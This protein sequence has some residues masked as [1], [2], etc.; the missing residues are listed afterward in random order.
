MRPDA[1]SPDAPVAGFNSRMV[2]YVDAKRLQ[3]ADWGRVVGKYAAEAKTHSK[4]LPFLDTYRTMCFAPPP[5][6][7]RVLEK[8]RALGLGDQAESASS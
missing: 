3:G 8:V 2:K 6:F 4:W 5:E 7:R 1:D